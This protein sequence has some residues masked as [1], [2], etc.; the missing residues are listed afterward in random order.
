MDLV[1]DKI[2][3]LDDLVEKYIPEFSDLSV[4]TDDEGTSLTLLDSMKNICPFELNKNNNTDL[5][6]KLNLGDSPE[7]DFISM[8]TISPSIPP[9]MFPVRSTISPAE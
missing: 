9:S 3:S 2:V 4:A 6:S 7:G 5:M 1:E 8:A